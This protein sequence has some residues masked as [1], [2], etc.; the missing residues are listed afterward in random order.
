MEARNAFF[1]RVWEEVETWFSDHHIRPPNSVTQWAAALTMEQI[2][3]RFRCLL[4]SRIPKLKSK[5]A[6]VVNMQ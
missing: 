6:E 4:G 1:G 3:L 2:M 5:S